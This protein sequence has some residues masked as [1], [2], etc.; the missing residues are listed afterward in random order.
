MAMCCPTTF[1]MI[2]MSGE[3]ETHYS[4]T[5]LTLDPSLPDCS[6]KTVCQPGSCLGGGGRLGD[7]GSPPL[8]PVSIQSGLGFTR[9]GVPQV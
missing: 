2:T 1:Q 5:S 7:A 6:L 3:T 4:L 9:L 8:T